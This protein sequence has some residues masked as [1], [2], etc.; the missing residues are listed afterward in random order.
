MKVHLHECVRPLAVGAMLALTAVPADAQLPWVTVR[1]EIGVVAPGTFYSGAVSRAYR[2]DRRAAGTVRLESAP[3]WGAHLR[4]GPAASRWGWAI[5]GATASTWSVLDARLD[6]SGVPVPYGV[7]TPARL[8]MLA[9]G[10]ERTLGR[11]AA[12]LGLVGRMG[13][14]IASTTFEPRRYP[15]REFGNQPY[16][17][18]QLAQIEEQIEKPWNRRYVSPGVGAGVDASWRVAG[19]VAFTAIGALA[20]VRNETGDMAAGG[21]SE[22]ASNGSVR[23]ETYWMVVPRLSLGVT[24]AR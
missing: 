21:R 24:L 13:A 12:R 6:S 15:Q 9:L 19:R 8:T 20:A 23:R 11:P 18:A 7:R 1:P 14:S 22:A 3:S 4:L 17:E 5:E 16:T 2:G 10:V